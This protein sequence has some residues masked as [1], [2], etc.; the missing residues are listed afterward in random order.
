MVKIA[1]IDRG[2][3]RRSLGVGD[4][5]AL[6]YGDLGASIYYALGITAFYALGATPVALAIAGAVFSCTALTYAEMTSIS[7]DPGGS[8]Y[9]TRVA[10]N[11]LISFIAGWGLLLDYIV[12]IAISSYSVGPYL[13]FFFGPL[14]ETEVKILFTIG[15]IIALFILNIFGTKHSTRISWILTLL[16]VITQL[17]IIAIGAYFLLN[18]PEVISH[19]K[20]GVKNSLWSPSWND[21][22]KGTVMAMVAYTGIESM[23]QLTREAKTPS[24][25][26]PR[27]ILL[28]MTIL[29]L[30]YFG[31]STV[32][33]SAMSPHELSTTY[34]DNPVA[35]IV[36]A[37]PFGSKFLGGWVGILAAVLLFVSANA[38][39]IGSSRLCFNMSEYY[40]IPRVMY[41]LHPKYKTPYVSLATFGGFAALIVIWSGGKL[42]FL[43]DLYNFGAMMAFT[44]A[45]IS[46]LMLRIK[47][48]GL[49]RPFKVPLNIRFGEYQIPIPTV[50]GGLA[51]FST[52]ILVIITK[53][54]GR[55]LGFAWIALG[56]IM[57]F[58]YRKKQKI[59]PIS[60][61]QLKKVRIPEFK[62]ESYSHILVPTR[63]GS[64]TDTIQLA[65]E[66]ARIHKAE[67]T[68]L[69]V[70]DIPFSLPLSD[71]ED[72]KS[73]EGDII[74]Q[75]AEAIGREF[76]IP[77]NL[78]MVRARGVD[79]AILELIESGGYDL[80]VM[81]GHIGTTGAPQGL[82]AVTEGIVRE[83]KIPVWIAFGKG[84]SL[85]TV[86]LT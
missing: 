52:W 34:L 30:M 23:T 11:D 18:L 13:S 25:T 28:A 21:F 77:M 56:L 3:L 72:G 74:L 53:P 6:G 67:V 82:G 75:Q 61:V 26:V 71:S 66:I 83:S 73:M 62:K 41:K 7:R 20:I 63:G 46:L 65:C 10:F 70:I 45:H 15:V 29:L 78:K 32:A 80:L 55:Y 40:Q 58:Y 38:G 33:L 69:H 57:Y 22:W 54:D 12:T 31:V 47:K 43:A 14:K 59:A 85:Q 2:T 5:F 86:P 64:K 9:F 60:Q 17:A 4:L 35:G 42:S 24:K 27:A 76:N 44:S 81:G 79:K 1:Q 39:L 50:I 84:T 51:T 48:P 8:A 49:K 16:T 19:L 37:L 36:A 68:A